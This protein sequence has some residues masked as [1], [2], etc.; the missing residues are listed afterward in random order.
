MSASPGTGTEHGARRTLSGCGQ[1]DRAGVRVV[2]GRDLDKNPSASVR[3]ADALR[4]VVDVALGDDDAVHLERN[5]RGRGG[6]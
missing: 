4:C 6:P 3:D 5:A 2:S 1:D